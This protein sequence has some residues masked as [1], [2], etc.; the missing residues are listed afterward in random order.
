MVDIYITSTFSA[1][2]TACKKIVLYRQKSAD[3]KV[4]KEL[5]IF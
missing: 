1:T 5:H 2:S 3:Q 4:L